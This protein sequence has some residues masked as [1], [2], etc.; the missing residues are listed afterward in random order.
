MPV[1]PWYTGL[2]KLAQQLG[3]LSCVSL[4]AFVSIIQQSILLWIAHYDFRHMGLQQVIQPCGPGSFLKRHMHVS[5]QPQDKLQNG[6][7]LRFEDGLLHQLSTGIY[8]GNRNRFFVNIHANIF[9]AIHCGFAPFALGPTL[10]TYLKR[11]A[12][13]QCTVQLAPNRAELRTESAV[14]AVTA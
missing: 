14:S 6:A 10:K 11:G 7:R 8:D 12:P 1:S 2:R 13:L 9:R 3:Q 5:A 4:V